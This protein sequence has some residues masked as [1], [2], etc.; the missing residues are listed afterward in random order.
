MYKHDM[1]YT[2][3]KMLQEQQTKKKSY[4]GVARQ[5]VQDPVA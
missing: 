2:W 3:K 4:L 5:K 1:R